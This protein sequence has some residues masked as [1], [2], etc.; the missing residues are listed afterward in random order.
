MHK[1]KENKRNEQIKLG[2]FRKQMSAVTDRSAP[3]K[4]KDLK[5]CVDLLPDKQC[6]PTEGLGIWSHQVSLQ[7]WVKMGSKPAGLVEVCLGRPLDPCFNL[8]Y[9]L[10]L[11]PKTRHL[12]FGKGKTGHI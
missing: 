8:M 6:L 7:V 2:N 11:W 4:A 1:D 12:V 3:E 9:V 5:R 10:L